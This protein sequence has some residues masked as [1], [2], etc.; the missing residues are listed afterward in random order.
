MGYLYESIDLK[1]ILNPIY[2]KFWSSSISSEG[3]FSAKF[4]RNTEIFFIRNLCDPN[5]IEKYNYLEV[6]KTRTQV[7]LYYLSHNK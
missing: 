5:D 2:T 7:I 1:Y 3:I 4:P 6:L